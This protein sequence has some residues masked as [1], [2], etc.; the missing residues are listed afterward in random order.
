[1]APR[2]SKLE[3]RL[4]KNNNDNIFSVISQVEYMESRVYKNLIPT[5]CEV[6]RS[7]SIN[8]ASPH[9]DFLLIDLNLI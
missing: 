8:P 7:F 2:T 3:G 5:L 1:M 4:P 9:D 6:K